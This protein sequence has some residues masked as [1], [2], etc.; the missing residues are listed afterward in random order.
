MDIG[1]PDRLGLGVLE[2]DEIGSMD[3]DGSISLL[4]FLDL[5]KDSLEKKFSSIH[6]LMD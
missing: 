4:L 1:G 6:G 5:V 3:L 2:G